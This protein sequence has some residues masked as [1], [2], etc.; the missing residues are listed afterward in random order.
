MS[1][2]KKYS[3]QSLLFSAILLFSVHSTA[4]EN[5][6]LKKLLDT[7]NS[8][9]RSSDLLNLGEIYQPEHVYAK[10]HPYFITDDYTMAAVTVSN[11]TF[12]GIKA[13]YNI[14]TDQLIIKAKVD[15]GLL[16]SMVTKNDWINSF[17]INNH[18]FVN[19]NKIYP[20]KA[21]QGYCEQV[22]KK[23][24]SFYIKYKKKFIDTYDNNTPEGFFSGARINKYIYVNGVFI[25]VNKKKDLFKL[26][27]DKKSIK[28]YLRTNKINYSKAS[29]DQL[30]MLMQFCD[31]LPK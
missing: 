28:K 7:T 27:S 26:Y 4:Q 22:Y 6:D 10:G 17:T 8:L 21:V 18:L 30:K 11:T 15:S 12:E 13:R 5:P 14:V 1:V 20:G 23:D 24:N 19:L 29:S 31:G 25:P 16:V 9:Y 3:W 2:L